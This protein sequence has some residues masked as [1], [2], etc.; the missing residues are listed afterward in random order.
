MTTGTRS[1]MPDE[2]SLELHLSRLSIP[3]QSEGLG[4]LMLLSKWLLNSLGVI[5]FGSFTFLIERNGSMVM[6]ERPE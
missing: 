6:T 4:L 3:T 5:S 2:M 1:S